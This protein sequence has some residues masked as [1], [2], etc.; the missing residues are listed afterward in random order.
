MLSQLDELIVRAARDAVPA[1][2]P[3]LRAVRAG[4][5]LSYEPDEED[6]RRQAGIYAGPLR[7]A[8]QNSRLSDIKRRINGK[9]TIAVG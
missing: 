2:Y 4:G 8:S 7:F 9:P 6:V 5:L 3:V 1:I